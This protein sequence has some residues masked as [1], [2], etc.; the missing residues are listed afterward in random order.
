MAKPTKIV[1]KNSLVLQNIVILTDANICG[2]QKSDDNA[3]L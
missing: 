1:P 2:T 3:L